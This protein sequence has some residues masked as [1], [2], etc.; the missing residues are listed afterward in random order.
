[1]SPTKDVIGNV[2]CNEFNLEDCDLAIYDTKKLTQN[3]HYDA[4]IN[5]LINFHKEVR[6]KIDEAVITP[7]EYE[8]F[9]AVRQ[10]FVTKPK[11]QNQNAI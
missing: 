9:E 6:K 5:E 8:R 1:M 10:T 3:F 7:E 4:D 11:H 2:T